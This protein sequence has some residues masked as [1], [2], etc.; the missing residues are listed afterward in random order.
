MKQG[1]SAWLKSL[2]GRRSVVY[3]KLTDVEMKNLRLESSKIR[4]QLIYSVFLSA[5]HLPNVG[6]DKL[7]WNKVSQPRV[8]FCDWLVCLNRLP[9]KARLFQWGHDR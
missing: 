2:L 6:W 1:Y 9:T 7:V 8:S 4:I 3:S 5:T